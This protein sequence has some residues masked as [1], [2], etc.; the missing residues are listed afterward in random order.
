ML[1]EPLRNCIGASGP[2]RQ[3]A[4]FPVNTPNSVR[5]FGEYYVGPD[6]SM[7]RGSLGV[8]LGIYGYRFYP[9][10]RHIF[11]EI[12][13]TVEELRRRLWQI[14]A[15]LARTTKR[16]LLKWARILKVFTYLGGAWTAV[17]FLLA[18]V[19][20][21]ALA[22]VGLPGFVL[23]GICIAVRQGIAVKLI[24]PSHREH[25]KLQSLWRQGQRLSRISP[26]DIMH[27]ALQ[28][29]YNITARPR[30]AV[31]MMTA[32]LLASAAFSWQLGFMATMMG[33]VLLG[34]GL[35][36][37]FVLTGS[38]AGHQ[39]SL[40]EPSEYLEQSSG[41]EQLCR[42]PKDDE[43]PRNVYHAWRNYHCARSGLWMYLGFVSFGGLGLFILNLSRSLAAKDGFGVA[44]LTFLLGV[45]A[46]GAFFRPMA[47][48]SLPIL[49]YSSWRLRRWEASKHADRWDDTQRR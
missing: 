43:I 40:G 16:R 37:S 5:G 17:C 24:R 32:G 27:P 33:L 31:A 15:P 3:R 46:T 21:F 45:L 48:I 1:Y 49:W 35:L 25:K 30:I 26:W 23:A 36:N 42:S 19:Q 20:G 18:W 12:V 34:V 13:R 7:G 41:T 22:F 6:G 14:M 39:G 8:T 2:R 47:I 44:L 11:E 10:R 9:N 29:R 28:S 38:R 4:G